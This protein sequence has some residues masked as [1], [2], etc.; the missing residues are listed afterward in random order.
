[1]LV[2]RRKSGESILIGDDIDIHVMEISGNRVTL[3]I[4][5]PQTLIILRKEIQLAQDA[6]IA[7]AGAASLRTIT[8]VASR[9][10]GRN[11]KSG[12]DHR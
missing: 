8:A 3:G 7:A 4:T 10:R 11:S 2:I 5:A 1:M 12:Q 6:N 9:F